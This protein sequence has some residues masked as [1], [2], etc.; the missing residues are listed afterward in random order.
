ML[1]AILLHRVALRS[2]VEERRDIDG[3]ELGNTGDWSD[4]GCKSPFMLACSSGFDN[5]V[6]AMLSLPKFKSRGAIQ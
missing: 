3:S 1:Q 5:I 2:V 6:R 4:P